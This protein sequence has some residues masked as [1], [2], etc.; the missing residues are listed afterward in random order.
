M[1]L[2]PHG[3]VVHYPVRRGELLNI[4]AHIDSDAW[5]EESWTRQCDVSEVIETY[6]NWNPVLSASL[7]TQRA[8]VQMGAV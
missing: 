5:T 7:S 8:M 3:H 1:W 6:A 4:V 2:G